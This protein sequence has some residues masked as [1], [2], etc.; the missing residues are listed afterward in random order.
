M[1]APGSQVRKQ[2]WTDWNRAENS[3]CLML[4]TGHPLSSQQEKN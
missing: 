4:Y 1:I 2:C 3:E